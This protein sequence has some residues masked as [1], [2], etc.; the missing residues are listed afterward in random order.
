MGIKGHDHCNVARQKIMSEN[1]KTIKHNPDPEPISVDEC[2]EAHG[3]QQELHNMNVGREK[4]FVVFF[5]ARLLIMENA[6]SMT[7][8]DIKKHFQASQK[9]VHQQIASLL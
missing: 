5:R 7:R 8:K 4:C 1:P 6:K 9:I 2:P 3:I